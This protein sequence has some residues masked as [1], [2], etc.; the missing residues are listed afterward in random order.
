MNTRPSGSS[1]SSATAR[2]HYVETSDSGTAARRSRQGG[3]DPI[4][5]RR[6][7]P[8]TI[9][10]LIE[11][12]EHR[13]GRITHPTDGGDVSRDEAGYMSAVR[14]KPMVGR[15][16]RGTDPASDASNRNLNEVEEELPGPRLSASVEDY[17]AEEQNWLQTLRSTGEVTAEEARCTPGLRGDGRFTTPGRRRSPRIRQRRVHS[18]RLPGARQHRREAVSSP[19]M[20]ALDALDHAVKRCPESREG[21][22]ARVADR[23]LYLVFPVPVPVALPQ[24]NHRRGEA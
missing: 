6:T 2:D 5:T 17:L 23:Q 11:W 16:A 10:V 15:T 12:L 21:Y 13:G 18:R 19:P 1:A 20:T 4:N 22:R 24:R 3:G 14:G 7:Y 8:N 9:P